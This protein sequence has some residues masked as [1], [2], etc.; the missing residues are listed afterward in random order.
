[1]EELKSGKN[2]TNSSKCCDGCIHW[3]RFCGHGSTL[4]MACHY[5][6][7]TG[8]MRGCEVQQ[9]NKKRSI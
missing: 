6:L 9:C 5:I 1:M 8:H 2:I 7:D 3:R 4:T